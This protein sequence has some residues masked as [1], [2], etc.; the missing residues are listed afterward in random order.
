MAGT[1]VAAMLF[2]GGCESQRDGLDESVVAKHR[3]RPIMPQEA[4][5]RSFLTRNK[6]A[7]RVTLIEFGLIGCPLSNK[8]LD[9][10]IATPWWA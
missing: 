1:L 8:G 5:R 6:L 7:G 4:Q 10:M 9:E 2:S 3:T